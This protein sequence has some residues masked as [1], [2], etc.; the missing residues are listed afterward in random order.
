M[1][2]PLFKPTLISSSVASALPQGYAIRP[3]QRS[4]FGAGF[5]DVL[6]VLTTVGDIP[7]SVWEER[8]DFMAS[9]PGE[10]FVICITD[11][12]S[13][14]VGVGSLIVEKKFIRNCSQV[15]HIEDVAVAADQQGKKLGLRLLHALDYIAEQVGCYK[16]ILDCSESNQGFYEKCGYKLAG[17]EMAHYYDGSKSKD[18]PK[19]DT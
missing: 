2:T 8:Y 14:I 4:D 13:K 10:Y 18:T 17:V 1:A 12:S 16:A 11:P 3:L 19:K 6:R 9:R 5:L 7:Q 15:G